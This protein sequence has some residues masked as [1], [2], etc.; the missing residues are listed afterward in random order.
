MHIYMGKWIEDY[1][2]GKWLGLV[3]SSN[4]INTDV[5]LFIY[6]VVSNLMHR[7][8]DNVNGPLCTKE[9]IKCFA[10]CN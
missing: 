2:I 10:T 7:M 8:C 5:D 1:Y 9:L 3:I 4:S 6:A